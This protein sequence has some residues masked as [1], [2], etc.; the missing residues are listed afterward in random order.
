MKS[1]A[2]IV[3]LTG[4]TR[5]KLYYL[6]SSGFISSTRTKRGSREMREWHDTDI[7]LIKRVWVYMRDGIRVKTACERAQRELANR[8][9]VLESTEAPPKVFGFVNQ[10]GG[11]GK[12]SICFHLAGSLAE[13]G[14]RV[15]CIDL[16]QQGNLSSA[17]IDDIYATLGTISDLFLHEA[18][19]NDLILPTKIDGIALVAANLDFS[20]IDMKLAGDKYA[21]EILQQKLRTIVEPF[22][23]VLLDAPPSLGIATRAAL[24]AAHDLI[25]PVECQRW[26]VIGTRHLDAA[27]DVVQAR[28]NPL[29]RLSGYLINKYTASRAVEQQYRDMLRRRH[30]NL[31]YDTEVRNYVAYA[32]AAAKSEPITH[33]K[34]RSDEANTIR[35][36]RQE[37]LTRYSQRDTHIDAKVA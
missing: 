8:S 25:I 18:D 6:E 31:M 37:V 16:D 14:Y 2:E 23:T 21:D 17:L 9:K 24:N 27:I 26:S 35:S 36:L 15:L 7:E 12:T 1:T 30:K 5:E 20:A 22:D 19:I 13:Q 33:Y 28:S 29:L 34:P 3:K 4:I 11:V 10:K 32:E